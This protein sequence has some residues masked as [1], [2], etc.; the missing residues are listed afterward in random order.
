MT[1]WSSWTGARVVPMSALEHDVLLSENTGQSRRVSTLGSHSGWIYKEYLAPASADEVT[2]LDR[3]VIYPAGLAASDLELIDHNTSWPAA[4]VVKDDRTVGVCLPLAP[5]AFSG[6]LKGA[7]RAQ[8][9]TLE[10]DLLALPP[11]HQER[12]GLAPQTLTDRLDV[13]SSLTAVAALFER[14]GLVYLDWSFAN[15]FWSPTHHSAYVIDVDGCSF[16]PLPEIGAPGWADPLV[17]KGVMASNAVDRYR[18]ALLVARCLT[19][20]RGNPELL[21]VAVRRLGADHGALRPLGDLLVQALTADRLEGRPPVARLHAALT[22]AQTGV[23][24]DIRPG[25]TT[26]PSA[27]GG[28]GVN[29]WRPIG[30]RRTP[31]GQAQPVGGHRPGTRP[32]TPGPRQPTPRSPGPDPV[33]ARP[34][35]GRRPPQ[36]AA[37]RPETP[38]GKPGEPYRTPTGSASGTSAIAIALVIFFV[39]LVVLLTVLSSVS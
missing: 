25:P 39:A 38:Q 36:P 23:P 8:R 12:R 3:L 33:G 16:G 18:V 15:A 5:D 7:R 2:R 21:P 1:G 35:Q 14:S 30:P 11:A 22:A 32:A 4:R 19:M 10:I 37:A 17:P 27:T 6:D 29:G 28:T 24:V 13:C 26:D 9:K 20:E 34:D 31:H